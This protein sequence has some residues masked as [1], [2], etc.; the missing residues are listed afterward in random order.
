M[1]VPIL[2]L[3]EGRPHDR[4]WTLSCISQYLYPHVSIGIISTYF[5]TEEETETV[6]NAYY[7]LKS[8]QLFNSRSKL[9]IGGPAFKDRN[10]KS[11][12]LRKLFLTSAEILP[13]LFECQFLPFIACGTLGSG[14]LTAAS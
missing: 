6:H 7:L 11:R 1:T 2:L 14:Y 4:H 5:F 8:I 3:T 13:F 10:L 12:G 9:Q